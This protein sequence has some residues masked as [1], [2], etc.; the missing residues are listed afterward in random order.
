M[1]RSSHTH[2][3]NLITYMNRPK[4]KGIMFDVNPIQNLADPLYHNALHLAKPKIFK[5][6]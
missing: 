5:T 4:I 1:R 6:I 3:I 2:P